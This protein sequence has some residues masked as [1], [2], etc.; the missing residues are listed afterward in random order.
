MLNLFET[1]KSHP[2]YFEQLSC[3]VLLC[4][5][6]DW[7]QHKQ[8]QD[9]YSEHNFIV[10]V[11]N[12][13]R[14]LHQP[15]HTYT[16]TE[17]KCVFSKKGGWLAEREPASNWRIMIFFMPDSYLQQFFKKYSNSFSP[18][19][20]FIKAMPQMMNLH[21]SESTRSFFKSMIVYFMQSPPLPEALLKLKFDELL[22]TLLVN[23]G[24][25][26]LLV[27]LQR[28]A[29]HHR[30]SFSEIMEANFTYNLS[31]S[32]FA[33]LTHFSLAS[34]KREFKKVFSTTPGKWLMDKRLDYAGRML[35]TSSKSISD[36]A[37]ESGFENTTHFSR[38][39][40]QKFH[41][42]PLHYKQLIAADA[43]DF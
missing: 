14:I 12:G 36:V 30:E 20:T 24:N 39:F 4:S 35:S 42:S 1:I 31:L 16:M 15:G 23:P 33:R 37:F 6:Y 22:F 43:A 40:K 41:E 32:E 26:D 28:I 25:K 27:H 7:P 9:L 19:G 8:L 34:F 21:V 10:Y 17:G 13:K 2:E 3:K 29:D 5:Q 38:V 18:A 11:L